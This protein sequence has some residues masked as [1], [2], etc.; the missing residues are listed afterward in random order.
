M[1]G[2]STKQICENSCITE[3]E[4]YP[5]MENLLRFTENINFP[6]S[7]EFLLQIDA[8]P[9]EYHQ[10]LGYLLSIGKYALD[11]LFVYSFYLYS[12]YKRS[13]MLGVVAGYM[14]SCEIRKKQLRLILR[15]TEDEEVRNYIFFLMGLA[16]MF[17]KIYTRAL[18]RNTYEELASLRKI[19]PILDIYSEET[20]R[21]YEVWGQGK[22]FSFSDS[23]KRWEELESTLPDYIRD[24][25]QDYIQKF[26]KKL[27]ESKKMTSCVLF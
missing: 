6:V 4:K 9:T 10:F 2:Y 19:G 25:F 21:M 12:N 16:K 27:L 20:T 24:C 14:K 23:I 17:I 7:K 22:K 13:I 3:E 18:D 15:C 5:S 26:K 8:D 11:V 1:L